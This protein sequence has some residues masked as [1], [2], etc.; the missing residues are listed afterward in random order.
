MVYRY[1]LSVTTPYGIRLVL[2][3]ERYKKLNSYWS[4]FIR[5]RNLERESNY[6]FPNGFFLS[7]GTGSK[8]I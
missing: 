7:L 1:L 4:P 6:A 3:F 8:N 2:N 5:T